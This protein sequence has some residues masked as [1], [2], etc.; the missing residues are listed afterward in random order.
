MISGAKA[1]FFAIACCVAGTTSAA[2]SPGWDI[3]RLMNELGQVKS[4]K[5]R[6]V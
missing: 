1:L 6:F 3:K 4:A 5:G 2:D